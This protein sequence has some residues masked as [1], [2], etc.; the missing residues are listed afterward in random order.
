MFARETFRTTY[1]SPVFASGE[2]FRAQRNESQALAGL[3]GD[4]RQYRTQGRGIGAGSRMD[5][6][7]AGLSADK[8]A[9]S[10]FAQS[11]QALLGQQQ[12]DAEARLKYFQSTTDEMDKLRKLLLQGDSTDQSFDLTKRGDAYDLDISRRERKARNFARQASRSAQRPGN[13]LGLI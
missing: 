5:R 12:D 13:F 11:Q 4:T 9:A 1:S 10:R 2:T 8:E 3:Y 6:Y 7:H